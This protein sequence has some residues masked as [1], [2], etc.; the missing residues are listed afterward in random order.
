[1]E[2]TIFTI[3]PADL[4]MIRA[5]QSEILRQLKLQNGEKEEKDTSW[6]PL[7]TIMKELNCT[8]KQ[9]Y[10]KHNREMIRQKVLFKP[11]GKGSHSHAERWRFEKY[12]QDFIKN[13]EL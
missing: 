13:I 12:K 1:M 3:K 10:L 11:Y 4:E 9:F 7:R 8:P 6:I 2:E 5:T